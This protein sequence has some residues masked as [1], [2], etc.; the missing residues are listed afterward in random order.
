[1]AKITTSKKRENKAEGKKK[2]LKIQFPQH[3][4]HLNVNETFERVFVKHYLHICGFYRGSN[5]IY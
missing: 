3:D 5:N 4:V 2:N 1:M